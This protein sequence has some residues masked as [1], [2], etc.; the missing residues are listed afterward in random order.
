MSEV[1]VPVERVSASQNVTRQLKNAILNGDFPKGMKL[2]SERDLAVKMKVSRP[3][4]REA[5]VTLASYGLIVSKQ[6]EG[7]FVADKFSENVLEFM[8]FSNTLTKENYHY[9]FDCRTLFE[10]GTVQHLVENVKEGDIKKLRK[11]NQIFRTENEGE[12][13]VQAEVDFHRS[14]MDLCGNPLIV[15]LYTIVLK[16]MNMSASYLLVSGEIR[17]EAYEAHERIIQAL[18]KKDCGASTEAIQN[19]LNI[20]RSNL[21]AY[22][23]K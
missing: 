5:I 16:F 17:K 12:D 11:I 1:F 13:Y 21:K 6:G 19:H 15:E 10:T 4:V 3:V 8:G 7:N 20:S 2:P 14:L 18:E 23:E 22:F 9:F